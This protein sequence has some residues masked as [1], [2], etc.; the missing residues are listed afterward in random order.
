LL[1]RIHP[2]Y[3][4]PANAIIFTSAVA[5]TLA[6]SG[7]FAQ[8]A[9]VSALARLLM[10][11]GSAAATLRLRSPRFAHVAAP[12]AFTAPFGPLMPIAA[13]AVCIALA[14]GATAPQL[15]GGAAALAIGAILFLVSGRTNARM[16]RR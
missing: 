14:A 8:I 13:M 1:A 11:G 2:I 5:L 4:T 7:S 12:A 16:P 3:R 10:Y 9:L 6:L 15:L